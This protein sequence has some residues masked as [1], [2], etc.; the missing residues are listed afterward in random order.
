MKFF[1]GEQRNTYVSLIQIFIT[2]NNYFFTKLINKDSNFNRNYRSIY[3]IIKCIS[4]FNVK[5]C[6]LFAET[7][8]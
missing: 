7:I 8:L 6:C 2:K 1:R 4:S 5:I 3:V